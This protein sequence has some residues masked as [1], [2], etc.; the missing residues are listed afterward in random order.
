[1]FTRDN[2]RAL[3]NAQP[4]IPFRLHRSNG[5]SVDVPSR[6]L[7]LSGRLFAVVALL[8]PQTIDMAWDRHIYVW[9]THVT[10]VEMLGAGPPAL[11][12]PPEGPAGTPSPAPA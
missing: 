11:G 2:L 7:G 4:F 10:S 12:S 1:M 6:E 5:S 9:H 3:L 8:D